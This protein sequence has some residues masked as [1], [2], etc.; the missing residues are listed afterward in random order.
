MQGIYYAWGAV[1]VA[2]VLWKG[3][4][5]RAWARRMLGFA[6]LE[7]SGG[8]PPVSGAH[9]GW[10]APNLGHVPRRA[11]YHTTWAL[12]LQALG[13]LGVALSFG[14][15]DVQSALGID[16]S[17]G[18]LVA[19]LAGP[20]LAWLTAY[21]FL[22]RAQFDGSELS[23]I[24]FGLKPVFVDLGDLVSVEVTPIGQ[25][26]L[27]FR[28]GR[29]LYLPKRVDNAAEMRSRLLAARPGTGSSRTPTGLR[30]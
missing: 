29:R 10:T 27:E 11:T 19:V 22:F 20:Y 25:Y 4:R 16:R 12:R 5:S 8:L 18:Y 1:L 14:L 23:S 30:L 13:A 28:D 17:L 15:G 9:A 7:V 2:I 26:R 3:L 21:V 6:P 24:A